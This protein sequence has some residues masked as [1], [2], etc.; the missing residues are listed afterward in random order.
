MRFLGTRETREYL[1]STPG[2]PPKYHFGKALG[3]FFLFDW[4]EKNGAGIRFQQKW[5]G[6]LSPTQR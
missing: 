6:G 1:P 4:Y 5:S 3:L 2:N